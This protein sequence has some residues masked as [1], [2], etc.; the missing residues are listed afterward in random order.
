MLFIL[1]LVPL[2]MSYV[3]DRHYLS[4]DDMTPDQRMEVE[5][6]IYSHPTLGRDS[7][8][9]LQ[10]A[11][12]VEYT[13]FRIAAL[14]MRRSG[15]RL[16]RSLTA[17]SLSVLML[18][19]SHGDPWP[20]LHILA[21]QVFSMAASSAA[22]ERNF[23]AFAFVHTKQRNCLSKASVKKLVYVKTNNL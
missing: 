11:M 3:L 21:K 15:S 1:D 12:V 14:E 7:T 16:F 23:S 8:A 19:M 18:W 20:T 13:N 4:I 17:K 10:D 22:S 2:S 9:E 5:E 6:M